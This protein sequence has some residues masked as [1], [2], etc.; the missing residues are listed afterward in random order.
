MADAAPPLLAMRGIEKTFDVVRALAGVDLTLEA[1]S[2]H[3]LVGE[4]GAGKSTLIK[5][6]TGAYPPNAGVVLLAGEPVQ[7]RRP[8]DAQARGI[9]AVHQEVNLLLHRTVAENVFLGREPHRFGI[10]DDGRMVDATRSLLGALGLDV[11]PRAILDELPIPLRQMIAIARAASFS[12]RVLVLDEPTSSLPAASVALLYDI[13]ERMRARGIGIIYVSH[14]FDEIERLCDTV[15][16]LRDGRLVASRALAGLSRV[17]L[18]AMMLGR[19]LDSARETPP[20]SPGSVRARAEPPVLVAEDLRRG[21]AL[22]GVSFEVRAG[23]VVGL[24]GLLGSGRTETVRAVFGA[25]PV[26]QGTVRVRGKVLELRSPRDAIDA[27]LGLLHEDRGRDGIIPDLSVRE[28]LTLVVL[29]R[30]ARLGIVTRGRERALVDRFM[31][32]LRIKASSAEQKIRELSGGNHQKVLLARWL[33]S[34]PS[35]LMLDE[36]TRGIDIGAKADIRA[37]IRETSVQ[38]LALLVISSELEELVE[39]CSR[40]IVVSEGRDLAEL[41]GDE[42]SADAVVHAIGGAGG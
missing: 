1:G 26:D 32:R 14:R 19:A 2:V 20:R 30:L 25:D 27:G 6:L 41:E 5:V 23:E 34:E 37:L 9:V 10:V 15:T 12:P 22:R 35:V 18:V 21:R 7:F 4:N 13:V 8:A 11:D 38:G 31:A 16:V 42:V 28:N 39:W 3:A 24:A 29:P 40:I 33:C 36:P 17:E